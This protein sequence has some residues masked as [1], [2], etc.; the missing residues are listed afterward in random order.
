M[1]LLLLLYCYN[2]VKEQE[3]LYVSEGCSRYLEIELSD[4]IRLNEYFDRSNPTR[5]KDEVFETNMYSAL[6]L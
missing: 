5:L 3:I 6:V 2:I 1:L 4:M